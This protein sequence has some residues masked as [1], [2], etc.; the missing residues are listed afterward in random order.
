V[1]QVGNRVEQ[2]GNRV[3]Q[4]GNR[5]EQVGKNAAYTLLSNVKGKWR[6]RPLACIQQLWYLC[7]CRKS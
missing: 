5:V 3:E 7:S 4:V 6:S 2:V 1:E